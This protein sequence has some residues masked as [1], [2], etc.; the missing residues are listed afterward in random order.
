[1]ENKKV[2]IEIEATEYMSIEEVVALGKAA[3]MRIVAT[4]GYW[5]QRFNFVPDIGRA[6][7]V[8]WLDHHVQKA[9]YEAALV[10]D[11]KQE[12]IVLLKDDLVLIMSLADAFLNSGMAFS[13]KEK[14]AY[15]RILS[16]LQPPVVNLQDQ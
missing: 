16:V 5:P 9:A 14:D 3:G 12:P 4:S 11:T 6:G 15:D 7:V 10:P 2:V 1:M 8:E 13:Q